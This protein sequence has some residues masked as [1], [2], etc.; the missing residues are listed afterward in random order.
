M[1]R[2]PDEVRAANVR[3]LGLMQAERRRERL[4]REGRIQLTTWI[5]AAAKAG[6]VDEAARRGMNIGETL[7]AVLKEAL[8]AHTPAERL[9][10][11]TKAA[12]RVAG[13]QP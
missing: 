9:E 7:D 5:S 13:E 3:R 4:T 11:A 2:L 6:L 10:A 1:A 12:A 8:N